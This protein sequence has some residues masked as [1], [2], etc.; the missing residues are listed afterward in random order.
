MSGAESSAMCWS[1]DAHK[2]PHWSSLVSHGDLGWLLHIMTR[3]SSSI[4]PELFWW[5]SSK[6]AEPKCFS[7]VATDLCGSTWAS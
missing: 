3:C 5:G 4:T 2:H 7:I 1:L 6:E